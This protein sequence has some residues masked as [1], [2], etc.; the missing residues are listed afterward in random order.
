MAEFIVTIALLFV[1]AL[2]VLLMARRRSSPAFEHGEPAAEAPDR[3]PRR[4]ESPDA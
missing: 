3:T 1:I 2:I 4:P